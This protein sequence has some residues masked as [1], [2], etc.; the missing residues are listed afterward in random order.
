MKTIQT[1]IY[2]TNRN[3]I[4]KIQSALE[5]VPAKY[6]GDFR[7]NL[8]FEDDIRKFQLR[9]NENILDL[10]IIEHDAALSQGFKALDILK[11]Q[12][13][14]K[15]DF[16][17]NAKIIF[18]GPDD[19]KTVVKAYEN[20]FLSG[21]EIMKD[22]K[23]ENFAAKTIDKYFIQ[24]PNQTVNKKEE[25]LDKNKKAKQTGNEQIFDELLLLLTGNYVD[26]AENLKKAV[27][28]KKELEQNA[29]KL[30]KEIEDLKLAYKQNEIA[31]I[32]NIKP[33]KQNMEDWPFKNENGKSLEQKMFFLDIRIFINPG[34]KQVYLRYEIQILLDLI[35]RFFNSH[36]QHYEHVTLLSNTDRVLCVFNSSNAIKCALE[37]I[38]ELAKINYT[39]N[40]ILKNFKFNMGIDFHD[41]KNAHNAG[42][43]L[44][45]ADLKTIEKILNNVKPANTL[46]VTGE[47]YNTLGEKIKKFFKYHKKSK[48]LSFYS[49]YAVYG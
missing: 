16:L 6:A 30:S 32:E 40:A 17:E 21:Y 39:E 49:Y 43:I 9:L 2:S 42:D 37:I 11:K 25:S 20:A 35:Y 18:I 19:A 31:K 36:F 22:L 41:V 46:Y 34:I 14:T 45:K 27:Y 29:K 5:I 3:L 15:P 38:I 13:E 23:S 4:H 1:L 26:I 28:E 48:N 47:V 12:R 7:F 24:Q 44:K 10:Y 33:A 8:I